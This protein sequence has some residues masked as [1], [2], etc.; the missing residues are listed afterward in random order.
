MT[1]PDGPALPAPFQRWGAGTQG[2]RRVAQ[3]E[4]RESFA[5]GWVVEEIR[6][7]RLDIRPD[8]DDIPFSE[9][10]RVVAFGGPAVGLTDRRPYP[11]PVF[12]PDSGT[13]ERGSRKIM[14]PSR[15]PSGRMIGAWKPTP[16]ASNG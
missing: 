5:D 10:A 2:P 11:G 9:A 4:I 8:L 14:T 1:R 6:P 12:V 13:I 3:R 7:A 15:F 16:G